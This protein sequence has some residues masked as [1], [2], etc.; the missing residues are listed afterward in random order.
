MLIIGEK[1]NATRKPVREALDQRDEQAILALA[2]CQLAAG[3]D[4]LDVNGGDPDPAKEVE[5]M[6]WLVELLRRDAQP[7]LCIDSANPDA[8]KLGL[9]QAGGGAVLNS[10]SLEA[11]R[12]ATM[13]SVAAESDCDVVA[14]CMDD[15]GIPSGVDDRLDRAARL[16]ETLGQAGVGPERVIIDPC[17]FPVSSDGQ[18]LR[19]VCETIARIRA[20]HPAVRVGGGVSNSSF[21]LPQRK[22]INVAALTIAIY[23]GMNVGIV[24]PTTPGVLAAIRAAEAVAGADE[25]CMGYLTAHREGRLS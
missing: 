11:E 20:E 17:F 14:L 24:D 19:A 10:I 13:L 5:N 25:F 16:I 15:A 2:E 18:A 6:R 7:R 21:G 22:W 23:H 9:S 8:V 1:I 4:V 12:L 3:A